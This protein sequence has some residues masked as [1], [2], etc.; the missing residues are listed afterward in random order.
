QA[1][2][3]KGIRIDVLRLSTEAS[4]PKLSI[5]DVVGRV[6]ID[7]HT[8]D[9][10]LSRVRFPGTQFSAKGTVQW[11]RDTLLWNLAMRADSATLTDIRFLDPR[12]PEHAVLHG[13]VT[14]ASHGGRLLEIQLRPLN[15][16]FGEGR[17]TGHVTA[18]S[19][20]DSGLVALRQGDLLAR[21]LSLELARPYLDTLPF[22]G[23]LTGQT[24]ID[25]PMSA[26]RIETGWSFRDS[27]VPGWPETQIDGRGEINLAGKDLGFQPFTVDAAR[28]DLGTV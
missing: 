13:G 26:L 3:E 25:G 12:F 7:G 15:L 9:V 14:V 23:R 20:A 19:A 16:T 4:D 17:L 18:F 5:A 1:P 2:R 28:V 6:T 22:A 21:N 24:I 10:D 8:L 11:P 27:L